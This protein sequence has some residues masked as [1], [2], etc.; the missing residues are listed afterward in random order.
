MFLLHTLLLSPAPVG[1]TPSTSM[2]EP[3]PQHP[4]IAG[5]SSQMQAHDRGLFANQ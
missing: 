4:S 2:L 5:W 3:G 1:E